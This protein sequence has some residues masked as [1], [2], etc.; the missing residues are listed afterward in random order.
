MLSPGPSSSVWSATVTNE[1]TGYGH[2]CCTLTCCIIFDIDFLDESTR[3]IHLAPYSMQ[4]TFL[5]DT[6]VSLIFGRDLD[7]DQSHNAARS[8]LTRLS[9]VVM[10]QSIARPLQ[11]HHSA[12]DMWRTLHG[13]TYL[14]WRLFL[15]GWFGIS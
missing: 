2:V 11:P 1:A 13:V 3:K 12:S 14:P 8:C 6:H 10:I 9:E 7:V 4:N 5:T 15:S